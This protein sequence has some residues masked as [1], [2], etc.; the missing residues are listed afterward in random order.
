MRGRHAIGE[1]TD[2][3][4]ICRTRIQN[5]FPRCNGRY[6]SV[7]VEEYDNIF[8]TES[9][10][11]VAES[12][13][14]PIYRNGNFFLQYILDSASPHAKNGGWMFFYLEATDSKIHRY[15]DFMVGQFD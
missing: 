13:G 5:D 14:R 12:D 4:A 7:A 9:R 2:E 15:F 11:V 1:E 10:K 3:K 6:E 8:G